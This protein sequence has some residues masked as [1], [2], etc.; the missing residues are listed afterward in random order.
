MSAA[1]FVGGGVANTVMGNYSAVAGGALNSISAHNAAVG[2]GSG[3]LVFGDFGIVAGG[4]SNVA[5]FKA[6]V[7]GGDHNS[8]MADHAVVS[9][10]S[11]SIA[12]GIGSVVGGGAYNVAVGY[13][14]VVAGGFANTAAG[15]GTFV[16]GGGAVGLDGAP[17]RATGDFSSILGG[18]SN[19]AFGNASTVLGGFGHTVSGF[20]SVALGAN[21][22]VSHKHAGAF[23][24]GSL[25]PCYSAGAHTLSICAEG[26]LFVN[27]MEIGA[28][29]FVDSSNAAN[30]SHSFIA[31]GFGNVAKGGASGVVA[32]SYNGVH[33]YA[34]VVVGGE[35]NAV[36]ATSASVVGGR[37]NIV[38][39]SATYSFIAGG[40]SNTALGSRSVV[41]GHNGT[42]FHD[43]SMVLGFESGGTCWSEGKDTVAIC[44]PG[45]F[46]VNGIQMDGAGFEDTSNN[47]F[48]GEY[49]VVVGGA[50]STA[51][52]SFAFVG[53]GYNNMLVGETA[54]IVGGQGNYAGANGSSIAG[55]FHNDCVGVLCAVAGGEHNAAL[56]YFAAVGGGT[57]NSAVGYQSVVSGGISNVA[58]GPSSVV[59]G[60]AMNDI[61]PI[62]Q[63]G[64]IGGGSL[65]TINADHATIGGGQRNRVAGTHSIVSGGYGNTALGDYSAVIG[66]AQN[67]VTGS[68]S[69][70][71]GSGANVSHNYA[72]VLSFRDPGAGLGACSSQGEG[73]L[74]LCGR[75]FI[76]DTDLV[77]AIED[78]NDR[79]Y[80]LEINATSNNATEFVLALEAVE[81][82]NAV[83]TERIDTLE[84]NLTQHRDQI[85]DLVSLVK[86]QSAII[87]DLNTSLHEL[88]AEVAILSQGA[89]FAPTTAESIMDTTLDIV[90][91]TPCGAGCDTTVAIASAAAVITTDV[92]S[93]AK[94]ASTSAPV[95]SRAVQST[96][97]A[98]SVAT[99]TSE[100]RPTVDDKDDITSAST[101]AVTT[102]APATADYNM[103]SAVTATA[104]TTSTT[105]T[106]DAEQALFD[107]F[108]VNSSNTTAES[109]IS[110]FLGTLSG[111]GNESATSDQNVSET[112]KIMSTFIQ[113]AMATSSSSELEE[114]LLDGISLI[115]DGL[116]STTTD[117]SVV[118]QFLETVNDFASW[119]QSS[120]SD[121]SDTTNTIEALDDVLEN[122]CA[123]S[124][125]EGSGQTSYTTEQYSLSCASPL[126]GN[127][128]NVTGVVVQ[129]DSVSVSVGDVDG[130]VSVS[131][132]DASQ[133]GSDNETSQVIV[134]DVVGVSLTTEDGESFVSF[135]CECASASAVRFARDTGCSGDTFH[136]TLC[137]AMLHP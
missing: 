88:Q 18:F 26:G 77:A 74:N 38:N 15:P 13:A 70:V 64:A 23:G 3:N 99:S 120:S 83:L 54:A 55:G 4:E 61:L 89:S 25:E 32:G 82:E 115:G 11:T 76:D 119:S 85:L 63:K 71:F 8:A 37:E 35:A 114:Q 100:Q 131:T 121:S 94:P 110:N 10:G 127:G 20:A 137:H 62:G 59:S 92:S 80:A 41:L 21:T 108:G 126:G 65:N 7:S 132:W 135:V 113:Y 9:G 101:V 16:G 60:G 51:L 72:G 84:G 90:D 19:D 39:P 103:T 2:G 98:T 102:A 56:G 27:G 109:L 122:V 52:G 96:A 34:S 73:T 22:H 53:G 48:D 104:T 130:T 47:F 93:T 68:K 14:A 133:L 117:D 6:T 86:V 95:S 50:Q 29:G 81:A 58:R 128:S 79:V 43:S 57:F 42:T 106:V 116:S 118:D 12:D 1:S 124:L 112:V 107:A 17:N 33:G 123:A 66:G 40:D 129:T 46:F 36:H 75:V 24:F 28:G 69:M 44:A 91:S 45:G 125:Q 5:D 87:V 67:I 111:D 49:T 31:G 134:S 30:G 105:S 97:L 136:H 78:T